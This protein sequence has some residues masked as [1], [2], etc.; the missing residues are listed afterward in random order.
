MDSHPKVMTVSYGTFSCTLDG[1]DD[2]FTT[3]QHVSEYFRKLSAQD[4][5]FGSEPLQPDASTLHRIASDANPYKIDAEVSEN[6]VVLR[7]ADVVDMPSKD[8]LQDKVAE[9]PETVA[10]PFTSRRAHVEQTQ[11]TQQTRAK[12]V[13][14]E[15]NDAL[16]AKL[17]EN[18]SD[19]DTAAEL[20]PSLETE[21]ASE[22]VSD[23]V[24]FLQGSHPVERW[25]ETANQKMATPEHVSKA[26]ALERLKAAVA[27]TEAERAIRV[28][29]LTT[30]VAESAD[31]RRENTISF[32]RE[33]EK[34]R[35]AYEHESSVFTRPRVRRSATVTRAANSAR[36]LVLD[37]DHRI[38]SAPQ[39]TEPKKKAGLTLVAGDKAEKPVEP[40]KPLAPTKPPMPSM[41][42]EENSEI[43]VFSEFRETM[44]ASSII[45]LLEASA[46]Y[47]TIV[48]GKTTMTEPEISANLPE[49][50]A[51]VAELEDRITVLEKLV[52]RGYLTVDTYG[53][54]IL[55]GKRKAAYQRR[56]LT[57]E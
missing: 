51:R 40:K 12:S 25:L 34:V 46:A 14:V 21:I 50:I 44:G 16:V 17:E 10:T 57:G 2:P 1:F 39:V 47:L 18:I 6:S 54:Y 41:L 19:T 56:Y 9:T 42:P 53:N 31:E 5:Y 43:P 13:A 38:D 37:S 49:H 48:D 35:K 3:M 30:E 15:T 8:S 36:P 24:K 32:R 52:S 45:E 22:T 33:L 23:A 11:P 27:A 7:P 26:N 4:R 28:E 29:S 20:A 55:E